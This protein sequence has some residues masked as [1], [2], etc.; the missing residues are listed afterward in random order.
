MV[1]I[2][3]LFSYPFNRTRRH[4]AGRSLAKSQVTVPFG[5]PKKSNLLRFDR[6]HGFSD[7]FMYQQNR[8]LLGQFKDQS[9]ADVKT[10]QGVS[11]QDQLAETED[12]PAAVELQVRVLTIKAMNPIPDIQEVVILG[13]A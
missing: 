13:F 2:F 1:N 11:Q 9:L 3:H 6:L 7:R 12:T 4:R 5:R 10:E 8:G